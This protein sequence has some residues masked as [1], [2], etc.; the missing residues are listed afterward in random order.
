VK[1][2]PIPQVDVSEAAERLRGVASDG[3]AVDTPAPLLVDV[4]EAGELTALHV[5]GSLHVPMSDFANA[6]QTLPQDRPL[7]FICASGRRSLVAA[8]YL[9]RQGHPDVANVVGG[10]IEW[11]KRGLPTASGP[12]HPRL[13]P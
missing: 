4:R 13:E 6:A 1:Q 5:P 8:D 9:R 3:G 12:L 2:S 7:L 10:I 11:R